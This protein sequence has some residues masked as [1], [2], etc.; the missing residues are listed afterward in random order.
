MTVKQVQLLLAYL[1]Y[2][3]GDIDGIQGRRTRAAVLAFQTFE[4]LTQDGV[5][6]EQTQ[7]KLREAVA[8]GRFAEANGPGDCSASASVRKDAVTGTYW[9]D[10]RYF[11]RDDPYIGCP[12][13]GCGGF[14]V[15]PSERLMRLADKVRTAA[16]KPMVPTSTVRCG[17]HNAKVGG[18]ANS[19]HM[20]GTA[21]DFVIPGMTAEQILGLVRRHPEVV[22]AYAI[23]GSAVHMDVG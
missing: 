5:A 13:G 23:N 16:G 8:N 7:E 15:E 22:Y 3:P 9:D 21:M 14:P 19:R 20:Q 4:G 18:V 12:C 2:D 10:I 17:A 1:G 6:G 11:G